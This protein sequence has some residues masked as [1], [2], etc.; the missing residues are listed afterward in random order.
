MGGLVEDLLLLAELDRGRPL[1]SEPVDLH[2]ICADAVDDSVAVAQSHQL[3]LMPGRPGRGDRR[4]RAAGPGGPQPRAQRPGPHA[5]R[6]QGRRCRPGS[7]RDMGVIEVS[8]NGP[9]IAARRGGAGLRPLLPGRQVAHAVPAP[10]W[11]WPSCTPSPRRSAGRPRC[12]PRPA[13]GPRS[14]VRIPLAPAHVAARTAAT[15]PARSAQAALR[16]PGHDG[17]EHRPELDVGLGRLGRRDP[18]R[19]RCRPRRAA[20]GG[21]VVAFELRAAQARSSI[22]RR[23][24]RRP[25]PTGPAQ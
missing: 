10:G 5:G 8:D 6:H 12:G 18:I 15:P 21:A 14:L 17:L 7:S 23:P 16:L 4:R 22:P 13:A 25:S 11:A 19:P 9:G 20:R 3:T 2:R 24:R 1:R